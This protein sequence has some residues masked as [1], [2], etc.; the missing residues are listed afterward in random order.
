V[1]LRVTTSDVR[2]KAFFSGTD[3]NDDRGNC[4]ISG[5][6]GKLTTTVDTVFRFNLPGN[7]KIN[8]LPKELIFEAAQDNFEVPKAWMDQVKKQQYV[9]PTYG[10]GYHGVYGRNTPPAGGGAV[11][12]GNFRRQGA[13]VGGQPTGLSQDNAEVLASFGFPFPYDGEGGDQIPFTERPLVKGR[14]TRKAKAK[15]KTTRLKTR[16]SFPNENG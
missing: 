9:A 2:K 4:Y 5:V 15:A 13:G 1:V 11:A 10:T 14:Q 16:I 12:N 3:D 7:M 6:V 8:P